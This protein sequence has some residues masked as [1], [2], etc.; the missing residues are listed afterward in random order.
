MAIQLAA[1]QVSSFRERHKG[2]WVKGS[3]SP[4]PP[5][6]C[7]GK[8][9]R[10]G[11]GGLQR[12]VLLGRKQWL[13]CA[14]CAHV[15]SGISF[16]AHLPSCVLILCDGGSYAALPG[17]RCMHAEQGCQEESERPRRE[18]GAVVPSW[19]SQERAASGAGGISAHGGTALARERSTV[20]SSRSVPSGILLPLQKSISLP[21]SPLNLHPP[22]LQ[23]SSSRAL[24]AHKYKGSPK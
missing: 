6:L 1:G 11:V 2:L 21:P 16:A 4:A 23:A 12:S 22:H 13:H 24:V 19:V 5:F 8:Q 3:P 14:P 9:S 7:Q 17:S 15:S 10:K 20:I 18:P